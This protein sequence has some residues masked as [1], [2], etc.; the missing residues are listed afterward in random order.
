M[1]GCRAGTVVQEMRGVG[2]RWAVRIALAAEFHAEP[3]AAL[4]LVAGGRLLRDRG[5]R[6][7]RPVRALGVLRGAGSRL[8]PGHDGSPP[9]LARGCPVRRMVRRG[10]YRAR[11]DNCAITRVPMRGA[12]ATNCH[13][14]RKDFLRGTCLNR[15]RPGNSSQWY[16]P[17]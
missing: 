9:G 5:G 12:I 1:A 10:A 6:A 8:G 16:A 17:T 13:F 7:G 15:P 3:F 4:C 11:A 14:S 2:M